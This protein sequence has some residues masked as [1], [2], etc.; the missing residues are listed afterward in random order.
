MLWNIASVRPRSELLNHDKPQKVLKGADVQKSQKVYMVPEFQLHNTP[1][2][3]TSKVVWGTLVG[4]KGSV[5]GE[6]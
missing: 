4:W 2:A 3:A 1:G 5:N 6:P